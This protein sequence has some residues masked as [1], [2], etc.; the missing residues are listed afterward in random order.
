MH[1]YLFTP[2]FFHFKKTKKRKKSTKN[3]CNKS[4]LFGDVI[5]SLLEDENKKRT[6]VMSVSI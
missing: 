2:K 3:V 4:S 6:K 1:A 5:M